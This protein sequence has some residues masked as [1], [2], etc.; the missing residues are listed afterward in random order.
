MKKKFSIKWNSSSQPRK[1]RKYLVNSP[2]HIRHKF[3]TANLSKALREKHG[4]RAVPLRK[5]DEVLVMR[6]KL[7]KKRAKISSVNLKRTR[8]SLEG[9]QR[10][11]KDGTKVNIYFHPSS[12][13][14]QTLQLDDKKRFQL[15]EKKNVQIQQKKLEAKPLPREEKNASDKK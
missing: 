11:R 13:Q 6:G 8:V 5:G 7:K 1:Q 12:L 3:L 2:L 4:E 14:I 10:S 9:V 15:A